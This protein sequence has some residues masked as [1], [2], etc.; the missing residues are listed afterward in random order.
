MSLLK[1][2]PRPDEEERSRIV[3]GLKELGGFFGHS[4]LRFYNDN[5]FQTAA[6]LTYTSLLAIVPM[7]DDARTRTRLLLR[8]RIKANGGGRHREAPPPLT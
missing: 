2:N 3:T 4:M 7:V 5:C 1:D 8:Q 6:A